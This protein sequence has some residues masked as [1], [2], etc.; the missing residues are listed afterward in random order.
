M[1]IPGRYRENNA[2]ALKQR[3]SA[4]LRPL[5]LSSVPIRL[6]TYSTYLGQHQS[7]PPHLHVHCTS[8]PSC[9][10]SRMIRGRQLLGGSVSTVILSPI[11]LLLPP[12][13]AAATQAKNP[14]RYHPVKKKTAT[15]TL[16]KSA[17]H[18]GSSDHPRK[19][20]ELPPPP[21]SPPTTPHQM[22]VMMIM[23]MA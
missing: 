5:R 19:R 22:R 13:G 6:I 10:T 23:M 17:P 18:N 4:N 14:A 7:S 8:S 3:S 9:R 20:R 11:L 16:K 2:M 1:H 21:P 15:A 12:V